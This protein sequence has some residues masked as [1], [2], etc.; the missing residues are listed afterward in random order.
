MSKQNSSGGGKFA[1]SIYDASVILKDLRLLRGENLVWRNASDEFLKASRQDNYKLMYDV[2]INRFDYNLI[3]I[4]GSIFQFEKD[5]DE[6][7]RYAFIQAPYNYVPFED[8]LLTFM[9]AQDIPVH[10]S[11]LDELRCTFENDYE[12]FLSEQGINSKVI[13]FR[14]DVDGERYMPNLHS[15]AHLHVGHNNDIRIPCA[16]ILTPVAFV[17]FVVK[18][19]YKESWEKC[20][21]DEGKK[22]KLL[23][24]AQDRELLK[25]DKWNEIERQELALV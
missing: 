19:T 7:L 17:V 12:Q 20:L 21:V 6:D 23:R 14:Y 18:Q 11:D 8:F 16:S 15:Y 13:Y 22:N 24:L 5:S 4:D 10:Q 3:L 25:E 2:A 1:T 9:D